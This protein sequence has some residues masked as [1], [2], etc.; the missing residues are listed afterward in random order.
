MNQNDLTFPFKRYQIQP[1]WRGDRPAKGR[2]R[3][4][5]QCDADVVGSDSLLFEAEFISI[6][7]EALSNLGLT[8]F[9]I[10]LNNRK[11]LSGYAEAIGELDKFTDVCVAIDKLDKIGEEGVKKELAQRDISSESAEQ[12]FEL[13]TFEGT[14]EEK[15]SFLEEKLKDSEVGLK[16]L[17]EMREVLDTYQHFSRYGAKVDFNLKLAR[18]LNYYTGT[19]YE[20]KVNNIDLGSIGGGGRYADL[21]GVFGK[22][23]LSGVG[24]SFGADRIYLA[25]EELGL[26]EDLNEGSAQVLLINFG[27]DTQATALATLNKLRAEGIS[28]EL[29]PEAAKMKK[30]FSYADKKH[31]P[32]TLMIG[33]EEMA[34]GKFKLKNMTSGE[35][36]LLSIETIIEKV[37][38]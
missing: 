26:F 9:T 27:G 35:Q 24:I 30:Q 21:T 2:Y 15:L 31:I 3:E 38:G 29:Y 13:I 16:G 19:I 20:V 12:L 14:A 10:L 8:D 34:T 17:A 36:E 4:F 25:M 11:I 22:P 37:K 23:G 7:D 32:Y 18:G 6:Y 5:H 1:V 28:S 33:Q